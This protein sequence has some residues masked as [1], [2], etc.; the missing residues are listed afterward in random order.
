MSPQKAVSATE[1]RHRERLCAAAWPW[2]ASPASREH[3]SLSHFKPTYLG[4][5]EIVTAGLMGAFV[6]HSVPPPGQ[7][8]ALRKRLCDTEAL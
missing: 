2:R 6:V 8:Q 5:P 7:V 4:G 1:M 3:P